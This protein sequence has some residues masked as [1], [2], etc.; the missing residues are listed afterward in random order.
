MVCGFSTLVA[1]FNELAKFRP[2]A[3]T[4]AGGTLSGLLLVRVNLNRQALKFLVK[5]ALRWCLRG[6]GEDNGSCFLTFAI[7]NSE[8]ICD[9]LRGQFISQLIVSHFKVV[10]EYNSFTGVLGLMYFYFDWNVHE[11]ASL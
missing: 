8:G 7:D 4:E 11:H 5:Y 9:K 3:K 6:K 2:M 1:E 10:I